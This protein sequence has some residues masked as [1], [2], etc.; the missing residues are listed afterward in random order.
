M[1]AFK[2][3][4]ESETRMSNERRRSPRIEILGRLHGHVVSLD[5]PIAVREMNLGGMA[6]ETDFPFPIG[7]FH[8]FEL[9]LGDGS[10]VPLTGRVLRCRNISD[11]GETPV[12]LSAV[13][14]V[15]QDPDE[16]SDRQ[17]SD[18]SS[19]PRLS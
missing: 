2:H 18:G 6:I 4:P 14:F 8:G 3:L 13:E 10:L 17:A 16:M 7:A 19:Q 5:A 11:P 12:F 15:D 1:W 9:T